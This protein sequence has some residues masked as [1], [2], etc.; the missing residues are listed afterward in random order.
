MCGRFE[1]HSALEIIAKIFGIDTV[2]FDYQPN[3]NITPGQDVLVVVGDGKRRLVLSHWGFVPSWARDLADGYKMINARAETAAEK[4][5]FRQAFQKQRCLVVADGFYE[6]KKEGS[7]KKPYYIRLR[8]GRPFG[9]AG[10]FNIWR[11]P[12]GEDLRT[13]TIIT[14]ESND[15]IRSIHGRMPV[16]TSPD[17]YDLW[18]DEAV[19]DKALLQPVLKACPPEDLE[20]YAVTLKVNSPKN[21]S[22]ENIQEIKE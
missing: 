20:M 16:I 12:E 6:W 22:P 8:S 15:L 11:S 3:Y 9:F 1:I 19:H 13:C 21:N 5:S 18:L 2:T 14:T 17:H 7:A 4:P 10:L